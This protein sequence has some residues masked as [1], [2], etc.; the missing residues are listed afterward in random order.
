MALCAIMASLISCE[1][2]TIGKKNVLINLAELG[3]KING[4]TVEEFKAENA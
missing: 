4:K 3:D 2:T 1:P